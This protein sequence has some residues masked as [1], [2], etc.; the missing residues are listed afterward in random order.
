MG[1]VLAERAELRSYIVNPRRRRHGK[2]RRRERRLQEQL[3]HVLDD[4]YYDGLYDSFED[5]DTD[6]DYGLFVIT[7]GDPFE[8]SP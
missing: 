1:T 4:I 8:V 6:D 2:R 3:G 7:F 5:D